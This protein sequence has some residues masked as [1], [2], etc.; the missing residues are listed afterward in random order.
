MINNTIRKII[1]GIAMLRSPITI[2]SQNG[3]VIS[4]KTIADFKLGY[5]SKNDDFYNIL[6]N[7][8]INIFL[9]Q[10]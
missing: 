5:V 8:W 9:R 7:I 1:T 2:G 4:K 6:S 10:N 3:I